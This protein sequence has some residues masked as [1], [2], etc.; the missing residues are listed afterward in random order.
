MT[1]GTIMASLRYATI[2]SK[3]CW[4]SAKLLPPLHLK[5]QDALIAFATNTFLHEIGHAIFSLLKVPVLGREEDAADAFAAYIA[6]QYGNNNVRKLILGY[7]Y[8]YKAAEQ[9]E[10]G[11]PL[12]EKLSDAHG[13]AAQRFFN[14]LCLAYG[15]DRRLFADFIDKGRLPK[16]RAESCEEEYEQAA[17]AFRTLLGPRLDDATAAKNAITSDTK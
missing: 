12:S 2:S 10:K 11:E 5:R 15:A 17:F 8:Q 16:D 4:Q 14:L 13:M 9:S 3:K 7:A 1:L 6:L